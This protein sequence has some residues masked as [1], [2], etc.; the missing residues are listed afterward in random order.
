MMDLLLKPELR[1]A[2]AVR[3]RELFCSLFDVCTDVM[4]WS[5]A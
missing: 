5:N 1:Y 2:R 3:L 4:G